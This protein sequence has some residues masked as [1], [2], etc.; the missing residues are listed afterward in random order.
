MARSVGQRARDLYHG[1]VNL[2]LSA[3]APMERNA[4]AATL[5]LAAILGL[6]LGCGKA[7]DPAPAGFPTLRGFEVTERTEG[8]H[9]TSFVLRRGDVTLK[10][11]VLQG[12]DGTSGDALFDDGRM[13]IEALHADALSPYPGDISKRISAGEEYL[14]RFRSR[15]AEGARHRWFL[16]FANDRLGYGATTK[17]AVRYRSLCGWIHRPASGSFAKVRIFGP[18]ASDE[19]EM[20]RL[21]LSL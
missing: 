12:V 2:E 13:G 7:P 11:E 21:F 1:P 3:L 10:L 15:D 20:E 19:A 4:K 18:L 8:R 5:I 9:A 16:L 17:D 14:P 6:L